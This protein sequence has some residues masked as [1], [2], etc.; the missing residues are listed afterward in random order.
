QIKAEVD[1]TDIGRVQPGQRARVTVE[2]YPGRT[3]IGTVEKVEPEAVV[4]QNVTMFPVLVDIDNAEGLI[5]PGMN[6]DVEIQ[7]ERLEDAVV[8]PND[9]VVSPKDAA[10]VAQALGLD[11]AAVREQM[12]AA[13]GRRNGNGN[14]G[15]GN[16][17]DGNG[18]GSSTSTSTGTSTWGGRRSGGASGA[19]GGRSGGW[20]AGGA[21]SMGGAGAAGAGVNSGSVRPGIVFVK[22][23]KGTEPRFV[24]LGMNDLDNSQVIRGVQPGDSVVLASVA[25]LQ[26]QQQNQQNMLKQRAGSMMGGPGGGGRGARG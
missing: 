13:R 1:E 11:P 26:Q 25:R 7:V 9:A 18:N 17:G 19:W 15:N 2:A 21:G 22:T 23:A 6:A 16:N 14:N 24:L 20:A 5:K 10:P 4:D 3:F 8:V 12:Q